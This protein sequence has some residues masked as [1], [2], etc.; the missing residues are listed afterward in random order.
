MQTSARLAAALPMLALLT[1]LAACD[2]GF[3]LS[4]RDAPSFRGGAWNDDGTIIL[5]PDRKGP[6]FRVPDAGGTPEPTI[7]V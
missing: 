1:M 6:L 7:A 3:A 2:S 4:Q 5:A